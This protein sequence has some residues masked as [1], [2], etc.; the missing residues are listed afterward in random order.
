MITR[1]AGEIMFCP[2]NFLS[3]FRVTLMP[4]NLCAHIL[5]KLVG[6]VDTQPR[7]LALDFKIA[8]KSFRVLT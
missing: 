6:L 7:D 5:V 8:T 3:F 2:V 4:A 1:G